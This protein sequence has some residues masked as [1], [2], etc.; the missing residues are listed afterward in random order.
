VPTLYF[1]MENAMNWLKS[2]HWSLKVMQI[3][4]LV[5]ASAYIYF[6][7]D[8][9]VWKLI[10]FMLIFILIPGV[11]AFVLT[12]LRKASS[13]VIDEKNPSV[14][15]YATWLKFTIATA[16]LPVNGSQASK[17]GN[18]PVYQKTTAKHVIST[19]WYGKFRSL[20]SLFT[21]HSFMSKATCGCG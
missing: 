7:V 5:A 18:V 4:L 15:K 16:V 21:L 9:F 8:S 13:K 1:G 2:L 3:V 12:S 11:T 19:I 17:S 10:G 6:E 14:L 20:L